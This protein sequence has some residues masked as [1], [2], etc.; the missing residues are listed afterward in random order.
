MVKKLTKAEQRKLFDALPAA[1]KNALHKHCK[2]CSQRGEGFLDIFKSIGK[3]LGPIAKELGPTL[4]KEIIMPLL[5]QK[6]GIKGSGL[7]LAG[8]GKKKT[9]KKK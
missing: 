9:K 3:F 7:K 4:L 1:R 5:K 6:A 8:A 2:A